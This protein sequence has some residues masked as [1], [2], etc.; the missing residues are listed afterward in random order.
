MR[1]SARQGHKNVPTGHDR[2]PQRQMR[3]RHITTTCR[4]PNGASRSKC[5][6]RRCDHQHFSCKSGLWSVPT[7]SL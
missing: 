3:L 5:S 4:W 2:S 7:V 6:S 1:T